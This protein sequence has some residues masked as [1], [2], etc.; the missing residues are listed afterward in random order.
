MKVLFKS[1]ALFQQECPVIIK[2]SQG[3]GYQ[4]ADLPAIFEVINPLLEKHGLGFT[5]PICGSK[6]KTILFHNSNRTFMELKLL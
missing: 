1:L 6:V 3:Y 4:F 5:Q 2:S